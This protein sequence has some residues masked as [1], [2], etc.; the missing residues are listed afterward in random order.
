MVACW[1]RYAAGWC[2]KQVRVLH[3]W[4]IFTRYFLPSPDIPATSQPF[5]I[6]PERQIYGHQT[7]SLSRRETE[8]WLCEAVIPGGWG[9]G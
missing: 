2:L 6:Q 3:I 5:E 8:Q 1:E 4:N 9:G 7:A